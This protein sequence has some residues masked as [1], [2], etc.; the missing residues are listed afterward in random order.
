MS[1]LALFLSPLFPR[2]SFRSCSSFHCFVFVVDSLSL[3][4]QGTLKG[5]D[6]Q[7]T[8]VLSDCRERIFGEADGVE[9]VALG[10]YIVRGDQICCV[11]A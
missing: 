3:P 5:L 7:T 4:P 9:E 6:N 1:L 10:L 8:I 2:V 11:G